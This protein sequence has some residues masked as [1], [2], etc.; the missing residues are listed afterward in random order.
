MAHFIFNLEQLGIDDWPVFHNIFLLWRLPALSQRGVS[1]VKA[2]IRG[3]DISQGRVDDIIN[4]RVIVHHGL[5]LRPVLLM[6]W[7]VL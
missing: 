2:L 6:I 1:Q 7:G 4:E 3:P 5:L